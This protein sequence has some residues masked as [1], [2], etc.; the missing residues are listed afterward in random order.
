M[1]SDIYM[2]SLGF[3]CTS[4]QEEWMELGWRTITMYCFHTSTAATMP[5]S[6]K[7]GWIDW[8]NSKARLI[9]IEDLAKGII[10][11]A[12]RECTAK[13]AWDAWFSNL[14]EFNEE[15]VTY[16]QFELRFKDHRK[17]ITSKKLRSMHEM[18]AFL[19]H[20]RLHPQ[21]ARDHKGQPIFDV[22]PAK[23]L[24]QEDV[25][26][27]RNL[28]MSPM[29]LKATRQEYGDFD[30][31]IFRQH[32]YQ[33]VRRQKFIYFLNIKRAEKQKQ[34]SQPVCNN[35]TPPIAKKSSHKRGTPSSIKHHSLPRKRIAKVP[36]TMDILA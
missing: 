35:M 6:A 9:V 4:L 25:R 3:S 16:S 15:K 21:Q 24:L 27:K 26:M 19:Y 2:S 32:I 31:G 20:R 29:A 22:H 11:L 13:E 28:S 34:R 7:D 30:L 10:P 33:E 5:P 18:Q 8:R 12:E 1:N 14:A 36:D 23:P 17:Q